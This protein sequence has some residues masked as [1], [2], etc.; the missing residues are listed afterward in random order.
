M[1]VGNG[2]LRT[3]EEWS[4]ELGW[5]VLDPAGWRADGL[6]FS[7]LTSRAEF[8]RRAAKSVVQ[9]SDGSPDATSEMRR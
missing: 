9:R 3:P 5:R 4:A 8:K 7:A 6:P 1:P 2:P